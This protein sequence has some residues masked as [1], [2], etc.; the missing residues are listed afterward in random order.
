MIFSS[1]RVN[2]LSRRSPHRRKHEERVTTCFA[3]SFQSYDRKYCM[4]WRRNWNCKMYFGRHLLQLGPSFIPLR[5]VPALSGIMNS[6]NFDCSCLEQHI[7]LFLCHLEEYSLTSLMLI[8]CLI[9]SYIILSF[10][11][12]SEWM[13]SYD[14]QYT[15]TI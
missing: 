7:L 1:E 14:F 10:F 3:C 2:P 8:C 9:P 15:L 11:K 13:H 4:C 12:P 6:F 5:P